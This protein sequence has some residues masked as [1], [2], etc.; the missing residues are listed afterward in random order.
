MDIS[1]MNRELGQVLEL[2]LL[3][4]EFIPS[5][6]VPCV[7]I[8]LQYFHSSEEIKFIFLTI[9]FQSPSLNDHFVN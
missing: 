5:L 2:P 3:F 6:T 9:L 4:T 7:F 1:L 8:P